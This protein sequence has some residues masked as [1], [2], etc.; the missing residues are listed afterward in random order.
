M[1]EAVFDIY[2]FFL[3][4]LGLGFVAGF[5]FLMVFRLWKFKGQS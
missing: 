4:M 3:T 2:V 5:I 1:P